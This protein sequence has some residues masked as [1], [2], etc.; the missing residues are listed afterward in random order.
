VQKCPPSP[1]GCSF[2][3]VWLFIKHF[4]LLLEFALGTPVLSCVPMKHATRIVVIDSPPRCLRCCQSA[5]GVKR[6]DPYPCP[7]SGISIMGPCESSDH[8][9]EMLT[10]AGAVGLVSSSRQTDSTGGRDSQNHPC[11]VRHG[12]WICCTEDTVKNQATNIR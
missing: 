4:L 3:A 1:C 11:V 6:S 10:V 12:F 9:R 8:C 7:T 2:V 5:S